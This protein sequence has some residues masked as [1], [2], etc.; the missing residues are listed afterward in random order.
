MT[1][2]RISNTPDLI[3]LCK[4]AERNE[5]NRQVSEEFQAMLDPDGVHLY[6]LVLWG[7]N[8]DVGGILHHRVQ[9]YAKVYGQTEPVMTFLDIADDDWK[10]L[11]IHEQVSA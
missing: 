3:A 6:V 11:T 8:Y 9:V 1:E 4:Q 10:R 2:Y 5:F 7:H